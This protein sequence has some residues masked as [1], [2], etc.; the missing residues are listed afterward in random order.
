MRDRAWDY[1]VGGDVLIGDTDYG[2]P[3]DRSGA[4]P[5]AKAPPRRS[6]ATNEPT[7]T[8]GNAPGGPSAVV[9]AFELRAKVAA[10]EDAAVPVH[11]H[12]RRAVVV[13]T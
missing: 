3:G 7:R 12:H 4:P 8:E 1:V 2:G 13:S 5:P 11:L 10:T 6:A 9:G